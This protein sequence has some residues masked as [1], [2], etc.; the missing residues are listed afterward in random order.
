MAYDNVLKMGPVASHAA[1]PYVFPGKDN[2]TIFGLDDSVEVLPTDDE[3]YSIPFT[4]IRHKESRA[5]VFYS[6]GNAEDLYGIQNYLK[7]LSKKLKIDVI[8]WDYAGYGLHRVNDTVKPSEANVYVDSLKMFAYVQIQAEKYNIPIIV[9]G[10]SLGS[11]PAI[12]VASKHQN[13]ITGLIV[14]SGFRSISRVVSDTL[15]NLFDLFDNEALIQKQQNVPTLF[16]HGK[17]DTVVPFTHGEHLYDLCACKKKYCFWLNDGGHNNIEST[18]R[19]E[20]FIR[21][22]HFIEQLI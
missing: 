22:N 17:K 13:D 3:N 8:S 18:Y 20:I 21:L 16:I 14:E 4:H 1:Q 6:H 19:S 12:Y 11:A 7:D 10:R 9:Y 15:H 2:P 5:I